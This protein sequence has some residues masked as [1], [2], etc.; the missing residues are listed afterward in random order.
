MKRKAI[1]CAHISIKLRFRFSGFYI[2]ISI[3]HKQFT[4]NATMMCQV[5]VLLEH[6]L[7]FSFRLMQLALPRSVVVEK[8]TAGTVAA[9]ALLS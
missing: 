7:C 8:I 1:E 3:K 6:F 4:I 5:L 9:F 2:N